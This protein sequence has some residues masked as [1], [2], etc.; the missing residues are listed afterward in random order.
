MPLLHQ[1]CEMVFISSPREVFEQYAKQY[2]LS[3]FDSVTVL[4]CNS[5]PSISVAQT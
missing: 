5:F 2:I 4:K 1:L 3:L